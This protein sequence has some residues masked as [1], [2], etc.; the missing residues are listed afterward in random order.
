LGQILDDEK[1]GERSCTAA[2]K[3]LVS[4]D[5]ATLASID[6]ALNASQQTELASRLEELERKADEYENRNVPNV[7]ARR[8]G[9]HSALLAVFPG[10]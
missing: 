5:G 6:T 10:Q 4:M 2:A 1:A 7:A 9:R 3:T 8:E